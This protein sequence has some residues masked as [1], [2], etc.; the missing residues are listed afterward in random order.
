M[1]SG[2][3]FVQKYALCNCSTV[4]NSFIM[5]FAARQMVLKPKWLVLSTLILCS[6]VSTV[7]TGKYIGNYL[8]ILLFAKVFIIT[9]VFNI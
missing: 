1:T 5:M 6:N 4:A 7:K 8:R 3:S 9:F 2:C